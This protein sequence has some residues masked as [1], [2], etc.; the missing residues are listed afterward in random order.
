MVPSFA[1][2]GFY[3]PCNT[4]STKASSSLLLFHVNNSLYAIHLLPC[5]NIVSFLHAGQD[6]FH[7]PANIPLSFVITTGSSFR[8]LIGNSLFENFA[9]A[10]HLKLPL[11]LYLIY[12]VLATAGIIYGIIFLFHKLKKYSQIS[13]MPA[14]LQMLTLFLFTYL[15]IQI[16]YFVLRVPPATHYNIIFYPII[17]IFIV[18]FLCTYV[19]RFKKVIGRTT[20][21]FLLLFSVFNLYFTASFFRFIQTHHKTINHEYGRP[22]SETR[23]YWLPLIKKA[24]FQIENLSS[25]PGE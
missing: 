19:S 18:L 8:Y 15:C 14:Q 20:L 10:Y 22:Y 3:S 12:Y 7:S 16:C 4:E 13:A 2:T 24:K 21:L 25:S 23:S 6:M 9:Q 5:E 11:L 1:F 17:S